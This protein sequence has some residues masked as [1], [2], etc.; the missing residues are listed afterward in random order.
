MVGSCS[1][2]YTALFLT[3][4]LLECQNWLVV[5][6]SEI[7]FSTFIWKDSAMYQTT[8][9]FN[10]LFAQQMAR[11]SGGREEGLGGSGA[12]GRVHRGRIRN[13]QGIFFASVQD[14]ISSL[15]LTDPEAPCI[16]ASTPHLL[17]SL[18]GK[19]CSAFETIYQCCGSG[20]GI[21]C[22]FDPWIRD[23]EQVFSRSRIPDLG[24]RIP[25][26]YF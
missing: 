2:Y 10:I 14:M 13:I 8:Q 1:S 18:F 5:T 15:Q 16:L 6:N 17:L 19:V 26:P 24:S 23:P 20:S 9:N 3:A 12:G 25:K 11:R 4:F 21:R 22:L 7:P